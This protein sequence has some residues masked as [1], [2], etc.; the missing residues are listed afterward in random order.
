M[1]ANVRGWQ[2][3]GGFPRRPDRTSRLPQNRVPLGRAG[4]RPGPRN[5]SGGSRPVSP[6][7]VLAVFSLFTLR[8]T[9]R[10]IILVLLSVVL[11]AVSIGLLYGYRVLTTLEYFTLRSVEVEGIRRIPRQ[12]ILNAAEVDVGKNLLAISLDRLQAAV[13]AHPW[14]ESV[15]VRRA[16]PDRLTILVTEKTPIYWMLHDEAIYYADASGRLIEKVSPQDM[17]SLPQLE[18]ETGREKHVKH[19]EELRETAKKN[20]S[21]LNPERAAWIRLSLKRG[22]EMRPMDKNIVVSLATE[23]WKRNLHRLN[24]VYQDLVKRGEM[25]SVISIHAQDDKVWVERQP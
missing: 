4:S 6:L 14:V 24:L 23:N 25:D 5:R 21:P 17:Q 15:S 20:A 18:V 10:L 8:V 2:V 13:S 7:A 3:G 11:L 19:L 9:K 12:D 22:L 16:F 1:S